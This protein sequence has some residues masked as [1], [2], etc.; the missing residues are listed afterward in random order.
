[1]ENRKQILDPAFF[2]ESPYSYV[3]YKDEEL[4]T[5]LCYALAKHNNDL[6]LHQQRIELYS[7]TKKNKLLFSSIV[8][9]FTALENKGLTY[10]VRIL[11]KYSKTLTNRQNAILKDSMEIPFLPSTAIS[12]LKESLLNLGL[13]GVLLSSNHL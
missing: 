5:V 11:K 1:M 10:K 13:E 2:R 7:K 6:I 4:S 3:K 12:N 8:D 9:L